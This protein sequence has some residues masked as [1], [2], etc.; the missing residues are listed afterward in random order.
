MRIVISNENNSP[1]KNE[2][3][4]INRKAMANMKR[5]QV[6]LLDV[7]QA[8]IQASGINDKTIKLP[9]ME[10]LIFFF[11]ITFV[12]RWENSF[13]SLFFCRNWG[14]FP[15]LS[16]VICTHHTLLKCIIIVHLFWGSRIKVSVDNMSF[17]MCSH[18][19]T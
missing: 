6:V 15:V 14:Q 10:F 12:R 3:I 9:Q 7:I 13:F 11:S 1:D 8:I 19:T 4:P 5:C 2:E 17:E 18:F 16:H